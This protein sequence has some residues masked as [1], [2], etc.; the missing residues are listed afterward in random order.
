MFIKLSAFGGGHVTLSSYVQ[1]W[2]F[3]SWKLRLFLE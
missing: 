1:L 3:T 2:S